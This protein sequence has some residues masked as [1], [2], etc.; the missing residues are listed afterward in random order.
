MRLLIPLLLLTVPFHVAASPGLGRAAAYYCDADTMHV[1]LAKAC[2]TKRPE[3]AAR[4]AKAYDKWRSLE[5]AEATAKKNECE[6]ELLKI[7]PSDETKAEYEAKLRQSIKDTQ[8]EMIA[9]F[10][11]RVGQA[12]DAPCLDMIEKFESGNTLR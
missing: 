10:A 8:A 9:S 1:A 5:L 4:V 7:M 3:L 2:S 6:A 12:G 11:E